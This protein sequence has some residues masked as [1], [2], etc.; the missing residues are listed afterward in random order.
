MINWEQQLYPHSTNVTHVTV[1]SFPKIKENIMDLKIW[2]DL[3]ERS[4]SWLGRKC[5]VSPA[6]VKG[7]LDRKHHP[8]K[9]HRVMIKE[10]TGVEV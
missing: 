2:L 4:M 9:K 10:I 3:N 7:W 6:A 5:N 1:A 8:S